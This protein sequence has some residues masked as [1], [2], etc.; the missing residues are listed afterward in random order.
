MISLSHINCFT[1]PVR[2]CSFLSHS[3][4]EQLEVIDKTKQCHRYS[5]GQRIISRNE[6]S[7]SVMVIYEGI[8]K[9]HLEAHRGRSFILQLIKPGDIAGHLCDHHNRHG[10]DVTAVEEVTVCELN[11]ADLEKS[12]PSFEAFQKAFIDMYRQEIMALQERTIRLVQMNVREKVADALV[13]IADVYEAENGNGTMRISLNRQ[14]ISEMTGTTKEQV[15]RALGEL[16]DLGIIEA[17]GKSLRI[18]QPVELTTQAGM[19]AAAQGQP[20]S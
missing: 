7:G 17:S 15:S 9:I 5:K 2:H 1:C 11:L 8:A 10:A 3:S 20:R 16:R 14:E 4:P 19:E 12:H 18:I 6:R 13:R